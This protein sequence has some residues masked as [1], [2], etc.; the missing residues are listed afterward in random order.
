MPMAQV[1]VK[2]IQGVVG[3]VGRGSQGV[4]GNLHNKR[5]EAAARTSRFESDE[6]IRE[7]WEV[8]NIAFAIA[9]ARGTV[10]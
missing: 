7:A 6:I 8:A 1:E 5:L 9:G 4:H 10:E 3:R 2:H